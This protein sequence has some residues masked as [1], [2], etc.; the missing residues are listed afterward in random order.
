MKI[1]IT[2]LEVCYHVGV[3]DEER[4]RPQRLLLTIEME[5][6][7]SA[8]AKSDSIADTVDYF[9]VSQR[10]LKFGDGKSW[11][12]IEK[13][14]NDICGMILSEFHPQSVSVEVKKFVIPEAQ[15]VSVA[16]TRRA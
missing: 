12:L 1:T 6:D 7:F 8:A 16:I 10:L 4:A 14:A 11:K 9:A 15:H 13:L 5:S 3:P 2:D